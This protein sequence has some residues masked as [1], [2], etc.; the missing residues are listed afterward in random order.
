MKVKDKPEALQ[1]Y[2]DAAYATRALNRQSVTGVCLMYRSVLLKAFSHH[3][4]SVTLTSCEA[5]MSA[6]F[7][8]F[9]RRY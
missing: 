2:T 4:S 1:V 6:G 3:Q 8:A 9:K 5:E 7:Q